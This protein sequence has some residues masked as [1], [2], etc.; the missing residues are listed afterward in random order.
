[1]KLITNGKYCGKKII[2]GNGLHITDTAIRNK[3]FDFIG[4]KIFDARV[5]DLFGGTASIAI[6]ALSR[7]AKSAI[8]NDI[9]LENIKIAK[10]NIQNICSDADVRFINYDALLYKNFPLDEVEII[11]CTPWF[12]L[13]LPTLSNIIKSKASNNQILF[14]VHCNKKELYILDEMYGESEVFRQKKVFLKVFYI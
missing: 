9:S 3:T 12:G 11:F 1:M 10:Y 7:G 5:I 2:G 14:V 6:E 4:N 13:T 8:I